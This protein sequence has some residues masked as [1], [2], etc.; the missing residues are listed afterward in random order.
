M[1]IRDRNVALTTVDTSDVA[2]RLYEY[3]TQHPY[4]DQ[5]RLN[6][7]NPGDGRLVA[8]V[9][10]HLER[11]RLYDPWTGVARQTP[12]PLRYSVQLF[13][14]ADFLD[15][16]GEGLESL[17]NTNRQVGEDDEFTLATS[18]HLLPKLV[19]ARNPVGDFLQ[20]P[21]RFPAHVSLLLEQFVVQSRVGRIDGMGRGFFVG[22]LV[23][24][25]D[26]QIELPGGSHFGWVKGLR[27][28]ARRGATAQESLLRGV[29]SV[30]QQ[31]QASFATGQPVEDNV[32]PVVALQ[33]DPAAQSLLKQV[34]EVSD[35]V[36]TLDRNLGLDYFDSPSSSREAGYL[37]DFAP[38]Y[39][40]QDRQRILLT[41]RSH[42]EL[43]H[44]VRPAMTR[45]GLEMEPGDEI[46]VLESLRSLS[47]RLALRLEACRNQSAEVVGLLLARW[48]LE[49]VG[50]LEQRIVIP[51]DAHRGW[52]QRQEGEESQRRADLLLVGFSEPNRLRFD[53]VEVKLREELSGSARSDL[54]AQ[55]RR[56]TG[57]HRDRLRLM[58]AQDL[59]PNPRADE[60]LRSKELASTFGVLRSEGASIRTAV[61]RRD[62]AG[63]SRYR[64]SRRWVRARHPLA[65]SRL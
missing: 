61:D 35:W 52:F 54:Y 6:V 39:L 8:E 18:N 33:L 21:E 64:Q 34:H 53:I 16:T 55:M 2:A 25:P 45:Y 14:A 46:L 9:L 40:Q 3:L 28:V 56:Q 43:E 20:E 44:L 60:L 12:P 42:L 37:L 26:T 65:R 17:L 5:L 27:P 50:L 7:F 29:V 1:G 32:A 62:G 58:F 30:T 49:R 51:L 36:L 10:R 59:Y 23:Q 57:E 38:E 22:G 31:V 24:E 11:N 41:T 15:A 47:G 48:L 63:P 13:A 19:F 4:V